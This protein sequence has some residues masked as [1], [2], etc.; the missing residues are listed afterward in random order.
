MP[1]NNMKTVLHFAI[2]CLILA[3]IIVIYIAWSLF[4]PVRT[5]EIKTQ[6]PIQILSPIVHKGDTLSYYLDYCKYTNMP[7]IVHRTFVDGQIITLTDTAGAF[8]TGCHTAKVSTAV[9]PSTINP[10]I[11]HLDVVVEYDINPFRK[12]YIHYETTY[13]TV[14]K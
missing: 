4:W 11:Y 10:G 2:G 12:E 1:P 6:Q 3:Y 13:F 9:V 5:L 14:V 8:P 7:S